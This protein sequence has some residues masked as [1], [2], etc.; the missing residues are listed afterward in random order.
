VTAA[1]RAAVA[2]A[3]KETTSQPSQPWVFIDLGDDGTS[4]SGGT[5]H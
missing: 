3:R 4:T 2:L 1:K 5:G